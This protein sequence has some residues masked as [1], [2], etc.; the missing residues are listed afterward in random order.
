MR[1]T[2]RFGA[3][4]LV[5]ATWVALAPASAVPQAARIDWPQFR[6][7]NRDGIS[8]ETG[9]L[10]AWPEAGPPRRWR[11]PLGDGYGGIA[12]AGGA[13]Y[14][15]FGRD[16]GE[17]LAA[18]DTQDGATRWEYRMD[19]LYRDGQGNGPRATPSVSGGLVIALGARGVLA[20]VDAGSGEARWVRDLRR[21]FGARPPQ[22]GYSGSPLVDGDLLLVDAGGSN[23]AGVVALRADT[24][25]EVWRALE[26]RAGYAAPI[27]VAIDGVRQTVFF[28]AEALAGVETTSGRPLWQ[29]PWRTSYDVNA[30]TPILVPPDRL[31]VASGYGVGGALLQLQV[32]DGAVTVRELW[33]TSE[34]K[35]QFSSSILVG[36]HL[37][38]FDNAIFMCVEAAT[39]QRAWRTR[40]FGQG[41]LLA[42]DGKLIVLGDDGTLALVAPSPAEYREIS[43]A[44]IFQSKTWT[45]PS[46]ADGTLYVRDQR[47]LLALDLRDHDR[48]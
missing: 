46:L 12:I 5:L 15:M 38:G 6:G 36:G 41:S 19:D 25:A 27:S 30:A 26:T 8:P 23:G 22:W 1:V 28:T 16:G 17:W 33:R 47:E 7:P 44:Q 20:A 32:D 11:R 2:P 3:A 48:P 45:M 24:G 42:A 9:L 21:D 29:F 37:Y 14:A 35:N 31:F 34:M 18:I 10:D 40:G 13:L 43:R 4:L 39:G